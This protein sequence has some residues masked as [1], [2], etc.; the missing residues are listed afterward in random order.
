MGGGAMADKS[1]A[2][3]YK[4]SWR[5]SIHSV[6]ADSNLQHPDKGIKQITVCATHIEFPIKAYDD[7]S[8]GLI[9]H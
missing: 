9:V 1:Y 8:S 5:R 7:C 2:W 3:R 6:D 4:A